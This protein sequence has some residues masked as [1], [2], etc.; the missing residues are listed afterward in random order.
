MVSSL[1][2][3]FQFRILLVVL[4]IIALLSLILTYLSPYIH[5]ETS[6]I[7]PLFGLSYWFTL[8]A[9]LVLLLIWAV[10]RSKWVLVVLFGIFIGGRLH[11]RMI[12]FGSDEQNKNGT[13]LHVMSYNVRLFD[14]YKTLGKRTKNEIFDYIREKQP[15]IACFQEFYHQGSPTSF[16]TQ[17]SLISILKSVDHHSRYKHQKYRRQNFGVVMFSKYPMIYKGEIQFTEISNNYNYCIYA[18]IVKKQDTFRVYNIHLQSIKLQKDDY[19]LFDEEN[20]NAA[21]KSSNFFRLIGKIKDAYPIRARQTEQITEHIQQSPYPVI[22]CG[23]FNDTPISYCYNKFNTLLTDAYRNT[24]F[25]PGT[26]YAGKIPAG[27]IDYIFHSTT[28]GS[29]DFNI[30]NEKLSD[31]YAIDCKLFLKKE[32]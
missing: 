7:L 1:K 31:H 27:R 10:L 13:E 22:V 6:S 3:I 4:T 8:V 5:P 23:D 21:E 19:A 9:N 18:D 16:V 30:Q 25:G 20:S 12:P 2:R 29:K 15:E 26:T 28:I 24:S 11:F 14:L 17:D 32:E